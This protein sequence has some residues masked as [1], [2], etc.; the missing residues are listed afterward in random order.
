M[1]PEPGQEDRE[2]YPGRGAGVAIAS[3]CAASAA[4]S[5]KGLHQ[6]TFRLWIDL[7]SCTRIAGHKAKLPGFA[8]AAGRDVSRARRFSRTAKQ[9]ATLMPACNRK[10]AP[11]GWLHLAKRHEPPASC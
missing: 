11:R 6:N 1:G 10:P 7:T 8:E 4:E 3:L 5:R 2:C 9:V